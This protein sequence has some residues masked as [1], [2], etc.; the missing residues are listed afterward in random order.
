MK[1][2]SAISFVL[3][4]IYKIVS[5]CIRIWNWI[6]SYLL[7]LK[8]I[9]VFIIPRYW[10]DGR[11]KYWYLELDWPISKVIYMF[12]NIWLDIGLV[13]FPRVVSFLLFNM[14]VSL[15]IGISDWI[16]VYLIM[17]KIIWQSIWS[18]LASWSYSGITLDIKVFS[19]WRTS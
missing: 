15:G 19:L 5:L 1:F 3:C 7:D 17:H 13:Q 10:Y 4:H 11:P 18:K 12:K 16:W 8:S 14:M 9:L 6:G 2:N